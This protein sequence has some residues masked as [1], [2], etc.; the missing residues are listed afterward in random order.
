MPRSRPSHAS[1]A[2]PPGRLLEKP[3]YVFISSH[4]RE[5]QRLRTL[6]KNRIEFDIQG[7]RWIFRA[8]IAES[9]H[10]RT[11]G[12][13]ITTL[14]ERCEIF[15]LFIGYRSSS[16]TEG[17]FDYA[18]ANGIPIL[19][20]EYYQTDSEF[21]NETQT[22]EFLEKVMREGII[23]RGHDEDK[24]G[25]DRQLVDRLLDDLLETLGTIVEHYIK[26]RKAVGR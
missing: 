16:K 19:A 22:G 20:Y 1:D 12:G 2:T 11:V 18:L 21:A 15:V 17:E 23:V 8:D 26:I 9:T 25:D 7:T 13:N 14:L 6:A 10:A 4:Q 24:F 5:F 3:V